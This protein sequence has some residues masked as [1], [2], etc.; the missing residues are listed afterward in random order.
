MTFFTTNFLLYTSDTELMCDQHSSTMTGMFV[1]P[2]YPWY[3]P[4]NAYCEMKIRLPQ[5]M[6]VWVVLS[7]ID[8]ENDTTCSSDTIQVSVKTN[9]CCYQVVLQSIGR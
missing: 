2:N 7:D 9:L 4:N 8:M 5:V 3:Y 6:T 1:S